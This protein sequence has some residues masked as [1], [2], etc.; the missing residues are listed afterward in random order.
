MASPAIAKFSDELSTAAAQAGSS[1]VTVFAR[2]RLPSSGVLW[3]PGVVVTAD[4]TV[5]REDEIS[6]FLPDGKRVPAQLAGHDP[7]T[8]LAVLRVEAPHTQ[9]PQFGDPTQ[10]KLANLAIALGRTRAGN[11]VAS[12]GI[13]GGIGGEVRTWRGGRLDQSIRLDLSLYPGFSGGPLVSVDGKILGINTNGLGRGRAITIPVVT[14]NRTVDELL[15][16]GYIARPYLGVAMQPVRIPESEQGKLKSS[17][18][19]GLIVLHVEGGSPADMAGIVLGDV[20]VELQGRPALDM[21]NIRGVLAN[22]SIG[23]TVGVTILRAK[24]PKELA[25]KLAERA[26]KSR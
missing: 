14:V 20:I 13:I 21:G 18:A 10:L 6:V 17:P 15:K 22:S 8:D 11:L 16:K 5:Q 26:A 7:G 12:S 25:I 3:R 23:D 9:V 4:H 19:G 2:R 1:V 24:E